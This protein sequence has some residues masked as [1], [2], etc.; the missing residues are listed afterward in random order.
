MRKNKRRIIMHQPN[1][2]VNL[3]YGNPMMLR[4]RCNEFCL[5]SQGYSREVGLFCGLDLGL[6]L[7]WVLVIRD[8]NLYTRIEFLNNCS[9][10]FNV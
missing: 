5:V 4:F 1:I 7:G 9:H 8:Y 2:T 6:R 10:H 3:W